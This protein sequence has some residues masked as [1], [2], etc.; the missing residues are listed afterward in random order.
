MPMVI[1]KMKQNQTNLAKELADTKKKAE[2][3][4]NENNKLKFSLKCKDQDNLA[5]KAVSMTYII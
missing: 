4:T 1:I 5:L 3:L 2:K